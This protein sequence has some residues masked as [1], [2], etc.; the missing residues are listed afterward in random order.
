MKSYIVILSIVVSIF[1]ACKSKKETTSTDNNTAPKVNGTVSHQYKATGCATVIV[2]KQ[3]GADDITLIPKD[4]LS[5][6]FD[7]DGLKISFNYQPL[8]MPQPQ[9]CNVGMPAEITN[10]SK[11]K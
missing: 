1:G 7:V 5:S 10:I 8:K 3:D 11:S 4:K 6:K 2:I 9:G